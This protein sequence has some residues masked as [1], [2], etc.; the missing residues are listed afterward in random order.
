[1]PGPLFAF[2]FHCSTCTCTCI[3]SIRTISHNGPIIGV[4]WNLSILDIIGKG[5]S[6][7]IKR[8]ALMSECPD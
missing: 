6:V 4:E 8:G 5:I 2:R 7:M 1:M 3:F